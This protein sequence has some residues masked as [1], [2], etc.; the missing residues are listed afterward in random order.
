[1]T[2]LAGVQVPPLKHGGRDLRKR[3]TPYFVAGALIGAVGGYLYHTR[4]RRTPYDEDWGAGAI[5]WPMNG[6]ALG[7]LLG[8]GA[9]YVVERR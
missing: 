7:G 1:M 2:V 4:I 6:A 3:L 5:V 9:G 8:L